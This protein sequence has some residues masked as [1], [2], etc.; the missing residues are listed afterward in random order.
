MKILNL[1]LL[2]SIFILISQGC[3]FQNRGGKLSDDVINSQKEDI[4]NMGEINMTGKN[5]ENISFNNGEIPKDFPEDLPIYPKSKVLVS[6]DYSDK[7]VNTLSLETGDSI[8]QIEKFYKKELDSKGWKIEKV[9]STDKSVM[10]TGRKENR[11]AGIAVT[12]GAKSKNNITIS[13]TEIE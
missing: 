13:I 11:T 9:F 8:I 12:A 2:L 5:G 4:K 1:F 10:F 3:I 6:I 7:H